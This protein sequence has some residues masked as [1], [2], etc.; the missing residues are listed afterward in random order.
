[1]NIRKRSQLVIVNDYIAHFLKETYLTYRLTTHRLSLQE[2]KP[3]VSKDKFVKLRKAV[4][5]IW[6][7]HLE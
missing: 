6:N 5:K 2:E 1:M 3:R 4:I 7:K